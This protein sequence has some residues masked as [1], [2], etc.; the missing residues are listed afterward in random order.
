M[1]WVKLRTYWMNAWMS[2][3]VMMRAAKNAAGNGHCY[4]AQV[5]H[6]GHDGLHQAGKELAFPGGFKQAVVGFVKIIQNGIFAVERFDHIVAGIYFLHL[7]VHGAQNFCWARKYFWLNLTTNSTSAI[8]TGRIKMAISVIQG[9]MVSIMMSTPIMVVM[10]VI[11]WVM[12]WFRLW[13]RVS[14][15]LV[16]RESTSPTVRFSK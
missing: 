16:M 10:L 1:G 5:A 6:K 12:L 11:S 3:M 14:T 15:S 9:L 2:P 13:P 8:E 7:A 4:I